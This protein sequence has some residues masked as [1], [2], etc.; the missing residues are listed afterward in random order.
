MPTESVCA[1]CEPHAHPQVHIHDQMPHAAASW[2]GFH[3]LPLAKTLARLREVV[4]EN[5]DSAWI[6]TQLCHLLAVPCAAFL[7]LGLLICKVGVM[8]VLPR[9]AVVAINTSIS[10]RLAY[11]VRALLMWPAILG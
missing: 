7:C 1:S 11:V 8:A 3:L 6:Q 9:G 5:I 10:K 4:T 2:L